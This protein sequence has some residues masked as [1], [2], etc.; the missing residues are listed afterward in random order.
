MKPIARVALA[1][2]LAVALGEAASQSG[3]PPPKVLHVSFPSAEDG[4]DPARIDD[5]YSHDVA[6]HIFE[7]LYGYDYLAVPAKIRPL[8]A[9]AMPDHSAD[10]RTWTIKIQ[11]GI[12]FTDDPAFKGRPRELVAQDYVYS[13]KRYADPAV[14]SPHW[15]SILGLG[16]TGLAALRQEALDRRRPFDYDRDIPG[17]RALDRYTLQFRLDAAR[18]RLPLSLVGGFR[19]ALAREV[20]EAYGDRIME[21]PV[22]T[23]PFKLGPWRR[24]SLIVLERNPGFRKVTY[25]ADP[26]ADDHEGQALLAHLKGRTLPMIDRVEIS[27]IEEGQP[28]WLAFLGGELDQINVPPEFVPQAVPDRRLAPYLEKRGIRAHLVTSAVISYLYFSMTD[29]LVGGYTPEKVALRRAIGLGMDIPRQIRLMRG[30]LAMVAQSPV[31]VH[32][33]GYDPEF[34]S[35]NGEFD[36]AKAKA[37]LDLYGYVD[38]DGDGWRERPDGSRLVLRVASEPDRASRQFAELFQIDMKAIGLQV[39]FDIAQWPENLKAA[40]AGALMIWQVGQGLVTPDGLESFERFYG[41]A[42]GGFNSSRFDLPA[43]N[44]LYERLLA[45]PDG[46]ERDALFLEA[47]RLAI[48]YMPEKTTVHRMFAFLSQPWLVGYRPKPFQTG[49]YHMVDVDPG[50]GIALDARRNVVAEATTPPSDDGR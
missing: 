44:V 18:P 16:I 1:L 26:A 34:L 4:F 20:V 23:G 48:A 21:H 46:A 13:Y 7:S 8:T 32:A 12:H 49:W 45:L 27:I 35:E 37:L 9:A 47:K 36:R 31:A 39:K 14:R 5:T 2:C 17:L 25:D 15:A 22:G 11:P 33:S 28:R 42:A 29:P 43:M 50:A 40:R 6:V 19:G 3:R 24:S 10:F 30:G 38:R 41:P